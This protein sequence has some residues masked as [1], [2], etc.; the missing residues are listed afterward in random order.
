MFKDYSNDF[1]KKQM[2]SLNPLFVNDLLNSINEKYK[3]SCNTFIETGTNLGKTIS[4]LDNIFDTLHTIEVS[5]SLYYLSSSKYAKTK[6]NFHLGDSSEVLEKLSMTIK[7]SNVCFFLDGHYSGGNT[8]F[9]EIH[10]PL[11]KELKIINNLYK[12]SCVIIIDDAR[13][14]GKIDGGICDWSHINERTILS[15][16]NE[17][18]LKYFYLPSEVHPEDRLIL[19]IKNII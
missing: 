7:E 17:R 15:C 18:I 6:I 2:P 11:Y 9:H 1:M 14:F 3:F 19:I 13:L 8:T 5:E 4:Q 12:G 10:V 16:L